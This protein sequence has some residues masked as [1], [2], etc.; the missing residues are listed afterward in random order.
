MEVYN[1]V[2]YAQTLSP[3]YTQ[4]GDLTMIAERPKLTSLN[5][6]TI[7][8][9]QLI[10]N[11]WI[12]V[13]KETQKLRLKRSV[14]LVRIPYTLGLRSLRIIF[15]C[16]DNSLLLNQNLRIIIYLLLQKNVLPFLKLINSK[17]N[18]LSLS[19]K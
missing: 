12:Q 10:F 18:W 9:K 17:F 14:R 13:I 1:N 6:H 5:T 15:S 11:A 2:C 3:C 7:R 16:E 19:A 4:V 8:L